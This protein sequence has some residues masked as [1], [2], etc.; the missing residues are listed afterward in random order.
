MATAA[1]ITARAPANIHSWLQRAFA[2]FARTPT[3][4]PAAPSIETTI[5][6]LRLILRRIEHARS[7][8]AKWDTRYL[9][10]TVAH[11]IITPLQDVAVAGNLDRLRH[12]AAFALQPIAE[13]TTPQQRALVDVQAELDEAADFVRAAISDAERERAGTA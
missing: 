7:E 13:I 2:P 11:A 6:D 10:Q 5:V 12:G 9:A 4:V 8:H 1:P 3:L